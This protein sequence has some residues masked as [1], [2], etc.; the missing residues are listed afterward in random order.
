MDYWR[1]L[2]TAAGMGGQYH[3]VLLGV[4]LVALL[5]A[6]IVPSARGRMR[7][8]VVM[9][10][11]SLLGLLFC[12]LM[13]ERGMATQGGVD[14]RGGNVAYRWIHFTSQML[15]AIA[16]INLI[17]VFVFGL[18][19][20]QL[21]LAP[22]PI[23][24]DTA[25]GVVYI[26]IAFALLSWHNVNLSGIVAT[27]AVVTAVIG[28]SLQDTLGN[29]MGGIALQM[30][31]S[32]A[33][34]DWIRVNDVE[35]IVREIRWRQTSIETRNCDTVVIPNSQLMKTQVTV[36]G[37]RLGKPKA[38]RVL[39]R[40]VLVQPELETER[41]CRTHS[42]IGGLRFR[43]GW[44]NAQNDGKSVRAVAAATALAII[45]RTPCPVIPG[46]LDASRARVCFTG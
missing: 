14:A 19:L 27:S 23:L 8:S 5:L 4:V 7:G 11:L 29:I 28:F 40:F 22:P 42:G 46:E 21:H 32:I 18:L 30:E 24:R 43:K 34:N 16:I 15:L 31:R 12:A 10:L 1:Q 41:A 9:A 36:L 20:A 44:G 37:R 6:Q 38:H 39:I 26:A 3:W 45:R 2:Q 33:V 35:G 17:G 25:V 13:L